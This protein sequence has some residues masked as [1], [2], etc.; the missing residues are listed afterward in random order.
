MRIQEKKRMV[1]KGMHLV[2]CAVNGVRT[3]RGHHQYWTSFV[4]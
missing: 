4:G 1:Q 3:N 2:D